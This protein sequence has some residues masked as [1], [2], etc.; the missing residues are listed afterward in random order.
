MRKELQNLIKFATRE[1]FSL[2]LNDESATTER[3]CALMSKGQEEIEDAALLYRAHADIGGEAKDQLQIC[4]YADYPISEI[5][6]TMIMGAKS[7]VTIREQRKRMETERQT[8][9]DKLADVDA[10]IK[11]LENTPNE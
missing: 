10:K 3:Y 2:I 1:A 8:L 7:R 9:L 11:E 6:R 4:L 5:E